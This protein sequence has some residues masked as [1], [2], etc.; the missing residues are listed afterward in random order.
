MTKRKHKKRSKFQV[1]TIVM[2]FLMALITILGVVMAIV[3]NLMN[4]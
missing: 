3:P 1:L 4:M 2:A